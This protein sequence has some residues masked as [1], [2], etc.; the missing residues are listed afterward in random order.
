MKI[1]PFLLSFL[2]CNVLFAQQFHVSISEKMKLDGAVPI[3]VNNN[4]YGLETDGKSQFGYTFKLNK[5]KFSAKLLMYDQN[6]NI[7]KEVKL[8]GGDKVYGP[9]LPVLR[10]IGEKLYFVY[11]QLADENGFIQLLIS[12]IN[13]SS[14][15]LKEPV[16]LLKIEQKNLGLMQAA[17]VLTDHKLI[18]AASPD[19]SK[20]LTAWS[21]GGGNQVFFSVVGEGFK[22]VKDGTG[23]AKKESKIN[24]TNACINNSGTVAICYSNSKENNS[25]V[26]VNG[27]NS[28]NIELNVTIPQ[29]TPCEAFVFATASEIKIAGT[30][31]ENSDNLSGVFTQTLDINDVKLSTPV[32]TVFP[33]WLVE[34]FDNDGWARTKAK[35]YGLTNY[36]N[37]TPLIL[38]DGSIDLVGE[39]RRTETTQKWAYRIAGGILDIHFKNDG[40]VFGRIPKGRVSAGSDIGDSFYPVAFKD[41]VII[42]Y[43]DHESNVKKDIT[44]SPDRSDN[45]KNSVLVAATISADGTV[46]REIL[47]DLSSDNYLPVAENLQRLSQSSVLIPVRKIKGMGKVDDDFKW[48][49]IEIQ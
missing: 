3:K 48:G 39:F 16:E 45:Y 11:Y 47:M 12:E 29:G 26:L 32:K 49:V 8:S 44:K 5:A 41:Q 37:I 21:S 17:E 2:L 35:D 20:L 19:N 18:F 1:V 14:L 15:S 24:L 9:F 10:K 38:A 6:L 4:Y 25:Y 31:K 27:S 7:G 22:K 42:F 23:I 33:K 36:L 46:K 34:Q 28:N 40:V 13:L 30:Y 43:N